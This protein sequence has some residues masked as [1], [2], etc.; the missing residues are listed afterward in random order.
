MG[1]NEWSEFTIASG[2]INE[3]AK[4]KKGAQ[5]NAQGK[6]TI[7]RTDVDGVFVATNY[8]DKNSSSGGSAQQFMRHEFIEGCIRVA[9]LVARE[10]LSRHDDNDGGGGADN[11]KGDGNKAGFIN[12][13]DA[14]RKYCREYV[15]LCVREEVLM[16]SN[17]FRTEYLYYEEVDVVFTK[18]QSVLRAMYN[19][20]RLREAGQAARRPK[21]LNPSGWDLLMKDTDLMS[22]VS[23]ST[24]RLA[25]MHS[26]MLCTKGEDKDK[27]TNLTFVDFLEALGRVAHFAN[28]PTMEQVMTN[29]FSNTLEWHM[30]QQ[31]IVSKERTKGNADSKSAAL[32]VTTSVGAA[33]AAASAAVPPDTT[34]THATATTDSGKGVTRPAGGTLSATAAEGGATVSSSG[35]LKIRSLRGRGQ[36]DHLALKGSERPDVFDPTSVLSSPGT[37]E[38][39]LE[40]LI[41]LMLRRLHFGVGQVAGDTSQAVPIGQLIRRFEKIDL[42]RGPVR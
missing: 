34:N 24:L 26:R 12:A 17:D 27:N 29:G 19:A 9:C 25:M 35:D 15:E 21:R 22:T 28:F 31:V 2:V 14:L 38:A 5:S 3:D 20:Y 40:V 4:A 7:R 10:E 23:F 16:D 11:N 32:Q 8:E 36:A 39:R 41:D 37:L 30:A 13:G 1:L 33:G 18:H 6:A 42:D